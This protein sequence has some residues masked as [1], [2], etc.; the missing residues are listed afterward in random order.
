MT[1]KSKSNK[2]KKRTIDLSEPEQ[3]ELEMLLDRLR[4]QDPEGR[5]LDNYLLTLRQILAGREAMVAALVDRLSQE[6]TAVG[7]RVHLALRDLVSGGQCLRV[8]KQAEYRFRQRGFG[9]LAT[10]SEEAGQRPVVLVPGEKRRPEAYLAATPRGSLFVLVR[11]PLPDSNVWMLG[12]V[13]LSSP[14]LIE[15]VQVVEG[16]RKGYR[17]LIRG[18]EGSGHGLPVP[19]PVS[20]GSRFLFD[21]MD[22]RPDVMQGDHGIQLQRLLKPYRVSSEEDTFVGE[23]TR[24]LEDRLPEVSTLFSNTKRLLPLGVYST[25]FDRDT[26]EPFWNEIKAVDNSVLIVSEEVQNELVDGIIARATDVLFGGGKARV[27][28]VHLEEVALYWRL[29]GDLEKASD[30]LALARYVRHA[31]RPSDNKLLRLI[32]E[33]ALVL[34]FGE[35]VGCLEDECMGEGEGEG[36]GQL[37]LERTES[38]IILPRGFSR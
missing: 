18:L 9:K 30:A 36:E 32:V 28:E 26:V 20:H 11:A 35:E 31:S 38:G 29:R 25:A 3:Q 21:A 33:T 17:E 22:L 23:M 19:I 34:H 4:V 1:R 14:C 24:D 12:T 15:Y 27:V 6:G 5:S 8:M 37:V 13:L 16:S 7:F 2:P 10:G